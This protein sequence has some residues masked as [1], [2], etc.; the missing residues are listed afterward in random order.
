MKLMPEKR[1][2]FLDLPKLL[3]DNYSEDREHLLE[4][5]TDINDLWT[6]HLAT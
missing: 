6:T 5:F 4:H 3:E 1:I 2:K